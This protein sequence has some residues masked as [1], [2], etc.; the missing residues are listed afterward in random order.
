M[1]DVFFTGTSKVTINYKI[2]KN[3]HQTLNCTT[4]TM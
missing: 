4:K 2:S 3:S 1:Y